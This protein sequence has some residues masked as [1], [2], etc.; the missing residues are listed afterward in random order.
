MSETPVEETLTRIAEDL[1]T[2]SETLAEI[3]T[4]FQ[5]SVRQ[6]IPQLTSM[7]KDPTAPDWAARLNRGSEIPETITCQSCDAQCDSLA[8][9]LQKGWVELCYD[10]GPSWNFLGECPAC[11]EED[12]IRNEEMNRKKPTE[13]TPDQSQKSLFTE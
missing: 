3:Q 10:D 13:E 8:E 2:I 1:K 4:D 5:W 11:R 12:E 7:P 6:L 9:A